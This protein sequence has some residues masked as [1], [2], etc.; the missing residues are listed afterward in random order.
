M[1]ER[2]DAVVVGAGPNGLAAAVRLAQA[3]RSVVVLE[4]AEEIGGGA[5][6]RELTLPGFHHDVCSA[7]HP[8]GIGSPFFRSLPL[9]EHGLEW[10]HPDVPV[11]HPLD[12]GSAVLLHRSIDETAAN[13]GPDGDAWRAT[14][15]PL[16]QR[17]DALVEELT[18]PIAHLPRHPLLLARFGRDAARSLE[19]WAGSRFVGS[20]VRALVSGLAAHTIQ[21]LDRP[22]TAALGVLFPAAAHAVGFPMARG[23][24][25]AITDALSSLLSS[26]G[27]D[28]VTSRP[29]RSVGD[30]PP[31]G[32]VL[33]DLT[34]RQV[35]AIGGD[36]LPARFRRLIRGFRHG[37]GVFKLDYAL[38]G[39]VPWKA[40]AA[41]RA[42]TLHL[43]GTLEEIAASEK[44][45]AAGRHTDRPYVLVAQQS[46]FDGT[47][48]PHGKH[49]LWAYCHVPAGSLVDMTEP[50][51]RQL[52]RF[53]P[54]FRDLVLARSTLNT[55]ELEAYNENYIGGD[56][57]GGS[58]DGLQLLARPWPALDP[59]ALG[60]TGWYLC[61]AST[62]PGGGVHG[63][64][65]YYAAGSVLRRSRR[66]R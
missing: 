61:S 21:S 59:Y 34:P 58:Q 52:E 16:A 24:S 54:G 3:G 50:V 46:P 29:V 5:R 51:E 14:M 41:A 7:I 20:R 39:P 42:G 10:V 63:M 17:F 26:L 18:R 49:T 11:A 37:P 9:A 4:A 62:P 23:G 57:T 55:V 33:F 53:A 15:E 65:G 48:A 22:M 60:D 64:C 36:R 47:R 66:R 27:G 43:G 19:G 44:A 35:L 13:L 56:I 45:T 31:A 25:R 1:A 8:L 12:D 2:H 28:I 30:L 6:T 38:D 40:E 32:V